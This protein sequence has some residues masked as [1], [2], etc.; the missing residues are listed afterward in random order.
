METCTI[1]T[2]KIALWGFS[3]GTTINALM[4]TKIEHIKA[5]IMVGAVS[6]KNDSFRRS[7][8]DEHVY[9]LIVDNWKTLAQSKQQELL[10]GISPL[11]LIDDMISKPAF[12]FLHGAKDKRTPAN[13]MLKYVQALQNKQHTIELHL[14]SEGTHSLYKYQPR[15]MKEIVSWLDLH[16]K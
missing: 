13:R 2:T 1:D 14:Y 8:F 10:K 15:V 9:P 5:V 11:H 4:L 12:L 7:E 6:Q 3:R 16:L